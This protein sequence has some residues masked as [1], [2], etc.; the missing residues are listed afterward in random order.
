MATARVRKPLVV[1]RVHT[2]GGRRYGFNAKAGWLS[3]YNSEIH[4]VLSGW[5]PVNKPAHI[6]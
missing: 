6:K 2:V 1:T 5:L 4:A 3:W